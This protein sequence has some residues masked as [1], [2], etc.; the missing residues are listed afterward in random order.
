[1]NCP[2]GRS[3]WGLVL[4]AMKP[5]ANVPLIVKANAGLPEYVDGKQY[6]PVEPKLLLLKM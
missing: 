1:M 3:I 4:E 5:C 6:F 2:A